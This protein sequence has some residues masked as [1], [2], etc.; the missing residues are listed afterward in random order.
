MIIIEVSSLVQ[1]VTPRY[2]RLSYV[3]LRN[4]Y[5]QKKQYGMTFIEQVCISFF[6]LFVWLSLSKPIINNFNFN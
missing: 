5:L 3:T 6:L 1:I 2:V 4:N